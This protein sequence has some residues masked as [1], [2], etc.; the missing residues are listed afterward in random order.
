LSVETVWA[1]A[2]GFDAYRRSKI[3][4]ERAAWDFMADKRTEFAT[5]LPG[6]VFGPILSRESMGSASIIEGLLRG[7]PP[8]LPK[9]GFWVT[10]VRDLA[11]LHIRAMLAPE[12][13]GERFLCAGE[14]LWMSQVAA[15]LRTALGARADKVPARELSNPA[16]RLLSLFVARLREITPLLGV[17]I[18]MTTQKARRMLDFEPR[19]AEE[20][21]RDCALSLI[22]SW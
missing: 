14:F 19:P 5:V 20:T 18:E 3:L 1:D 15:I 21:L 9:I 11:E 13:K 7:R 2:D 6:A 12:A 4:A 22:A 17:K 10:D 8:G 16:V